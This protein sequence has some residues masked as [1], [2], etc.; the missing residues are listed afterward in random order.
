MLLR[1]Y[2]FLRTTGGGSV[3]TARAFG[4][5]IILV[6]IFQKLSEVR[7][8]AQICSD[9]GIDGFSFLH[10]LIR[11]WCFFFVMSFAHTKAFELIKKAQYKELELVF[12]TVSGRDKNTMFT[13]AAKTLT[14]NVL[15]DIQLNYILN[16]MQIYHKNKLMPMYNDAYNRF[17]EEEAPIHRKRKYEELANADFIEDVMKLHYKRRST[18]TPT[19]TCSTEF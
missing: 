8:S 5:D 14:P 3:M 13:G 10:L 9:T 11:C 2:K 1:A 15:S 17:K 18:M 4:V 7:I 19:S 6:K 16:K 12:E